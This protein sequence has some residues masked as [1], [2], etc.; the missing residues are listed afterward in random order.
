MLEEQTAERRACTNTELCA[1]GE[2]RSSRMTPTGLTCPFGQT[3]PR[4]KS[5]DNKLAFDYN[6]TQKKT[7]PKMQNGAHIISTSLV[8]HKQDQWVNLSANITICCLVSNH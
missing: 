5:A 2:F 7:T 4:L 3:P 6:H 1:L 8:N